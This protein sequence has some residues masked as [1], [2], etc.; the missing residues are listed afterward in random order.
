MRGAN[1][2]KRYVGVLE[3][4]EAFLSG[5]SGDAGVALEAVEK[6]QLIEF[7]RRGAKES[8]EPSRSVWNC[9]L[10]ALRSFYD[11]LFKQEVVTVNP[12]MRI[13]R[14]KTN[15][16]EPVP[17]S[18]D[19]FLALV[20]ALEKYSAVQNRARNV[21]IVQVLY[22]CALRVSELASLN[23]EQVDFDNN[24]FAN[25]RTKGKK[26]LSIPFPDIVD[27][28]LERYLKER[29]E[30]GSAGMALFLSGR[31][32][33]LSVRSVQDMLK[34]YGA[35]A[36]IGRPVGPHLLRHSGATEM[37]DMG[38]PMRVVQEICGHASVTTTE[39]YVHV[40]AG[41]RRAA[42]EALGKR[43]KARG[44]RR[45]RLPHSTSRQPSASA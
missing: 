39:R 23:L 27:D 30:D 44:T 4:F 19:E 45:S 25:V 5:S 11:Y 16:R 42:I 3:E 17:L 34:R 14:L 35:L 20:D 24:L 21:A 40:R 9:R 32:Q 6:P 43:V 1:T 26:W 12:A 7:L 37:A 36:G 10:A 38:T 22:H 8:R 13:D 18:L 33:R 31:H 2:I 15:P 41:A 29:R 28:A